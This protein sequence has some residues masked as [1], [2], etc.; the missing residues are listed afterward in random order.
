MIIPGGGSG[1]SC[2]NAGLALD[3]IRNADQSVWREVMN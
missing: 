3:S 2:R 1:N